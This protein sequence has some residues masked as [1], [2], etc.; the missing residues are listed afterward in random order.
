LEEIKLYDLQT[1]PEMH[2]LFA[3]KGFHRKA[4][5]EI[6]KDRRI[7]LA[8]KDIQSMS[9]ESIKPVFTV[10]KKLYGAILLV[11]VIFACLIKA[12]KSKNN[13]KRLRA[14]ARV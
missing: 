2:A 7:R 14:V 5:D 10:L 12:S 13:N 3:D 8:E 9:S 1:K 11:T 6:N 4:P